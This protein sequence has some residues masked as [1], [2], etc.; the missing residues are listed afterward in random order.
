MA[1]ARIVAIILIVAGSLALA[2]GGFTYTRDTEEVKLGPVE[3]SIR[4]TERVNIPAWAGIAAIAA[5]V[6]LLVIRRQ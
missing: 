4:D 2:Y 3:L 1:T 6:V 5:G